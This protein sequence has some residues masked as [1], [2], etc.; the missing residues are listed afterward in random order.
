MRTTRSAAA[1]AV[2][3]AVLLAGACSS[4]TKSTAAAGAPAQ[5]TSSAAAPVTV[6]STVTSAPGSASG[7]S[8]GGGQSTAVPSSAGSSPA[9]APGSASGSACQASN[10]KVTIIHGTDADPDPSKTNDPATVSFQNTGQSTCTMQGHAQVD[11]VSTSGMD[12]PLEDQS[13]TTPKLTLA[14]GTSALASLYVLSHTDGAGTNGFQ[15]KSAVIIPPDTKTPT[16]VPWPWTWALEDQ[17]AAT[18]PGTFIGAVNQ[19]ASS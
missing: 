13:G 5:T 6:T 17:S 1:A 12:W 7:S 11:L 10:L 2:F 18:H 4:S 9:T 8:S 16:T 15:V 19:T 14:P 3:A